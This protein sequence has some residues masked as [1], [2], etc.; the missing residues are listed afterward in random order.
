MIKCHCGEP[1]EV[2][3][4]VNG[5]EGRRQKPILLCSNCMSVYWEQIKHAYKGSNAYEAS[6]FEVVSH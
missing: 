1:A 5:D 4:T 2:R 6:T 3:W